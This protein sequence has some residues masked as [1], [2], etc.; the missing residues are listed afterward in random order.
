MISAFQFCGRQKSSLL[1]EGLQRSK[2]PPVDKLQIMWPTHIMWE[3]KSSSVT[4]KS[5][6]KWFE[7]IPQL[8]YLGRF[9]RF[10]EDPIEKLHKLDSQAY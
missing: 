3:Q 8:S 10:M 7:V 1:W 4:P 6:K 2:V 9:F 5:Q